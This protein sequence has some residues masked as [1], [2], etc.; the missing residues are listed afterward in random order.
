MLIYLK[1]LI[2]PQNDN[3]TSRHMMLI[4]IKSNIGK[5][6]EF[7]YGAIISAKTSQQILGSFGTNNHSIIKFTGFTSIA[8]DVYQH[9]NFV[10]AK[11]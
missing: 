6:S 9:N 5:A 11:P 2:I 10:L 8:F 7:N 4:Y 3:Y 1:M